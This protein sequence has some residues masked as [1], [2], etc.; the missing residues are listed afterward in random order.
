MKRR[1]GHMVVMHSSGDWTIGTG[2]NRHGRSPP[3]LSL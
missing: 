3:T 2:G 1:D